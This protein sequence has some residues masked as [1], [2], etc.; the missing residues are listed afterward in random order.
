M[1][2]KDREGKK[3]QLKAHGLPGTNQAGKGPG[4]NQN[5]DQENKPGGS[6]SQRPE[7]QKQ[8]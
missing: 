8:P 1:E 4:S 2:E 3:N 7:G 5:D 6:T